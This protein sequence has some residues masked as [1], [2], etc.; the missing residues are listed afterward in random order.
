MD[1][2]ERVLITGGA[3]FVG[4]KIVEM[5]LAENVSCRV[6]GRNRYPDL[7]LMGVECFQGDLSDTRF[8]EQAGRGIDTVF[9]VAALAGIWGSWEKYYTTNVL[10]TENILNSCSKNGIPRLVYTSTPSVVFNRNDIINGDEN[11]PYADHFLCNYAKS[12]VLAEKAVLKSAEDGF[13][14][15][16]IRPHLIYGP[17]DPHL[18]PRLLER[19][20]QG[21]LKIVGGGDNIVDISYVDNVAHLH[22]LAATSLCES[23]VAN[24][25]VFFIGDEKPVKLWHWIND[26]FKEF[27]IPVI[28][29]KVSEKIAYGAGWAL[30]KT[31]ALMKREK[32]PP[33]TRF[34][35]EQLA[36]SHYFS[37]EKAKKLLG[38]SPIV[39]Y[40]QGMKNL[41][42]WVR[43]NDI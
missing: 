3:G 34:V 43:E 1:K 41:Y 24:G 28:E 12:K 30:E 16:A 2:M 5:L 38:Y 25:Q 22:L 18:I 11:L 19:G 35:A 4:R 21:K 33:M 31:Y 27:H 6:I 36:K 10:G 29:K 15:C 26:L 14:C 20:R 37:H 23:G 32:E 17:G 39:S 7:E 40:E 9:H 8:V 42:S 13:R